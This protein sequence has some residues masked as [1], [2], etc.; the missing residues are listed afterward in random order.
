MNGLLLAYTK[1]LEKKHMS[2]NTMDAYVRDVDKFYN[3]IKDRKESIEGVEVISIMAYV[4]Y[5]QKAGKAI[6]SIVRN[7]VS[8]RNF[9]KYLTL[10]GIV[11]ENPILYYQIP[12][13]EHSVPEIL[14]VK[15]VDKL[16]SSPDLSTDK[17]I[18]DKAMLEVMYAA[19]MK[20]MELLNL[21]IYDID[22]KL[23][24]IRCSNSR[25]KER[26][27]PIGSVAVKYLKNYLRIRP[28]LNLYNL[29]TLF[30]N[31]KG[32]KMSR[33][34]FWK[35]VKYYAGESKIDKNINA[36]TLRHSFAVHLL[37]NGADIKSV[38]ELLGHKD[39]SATQVYSSVLKR[40]KIA[41]IYKKSHPRA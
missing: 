35:I 40:N 2:K 28:E 30:L 27:V 17:G 20:V 6:S 7:I 14:T 1:E 41:E 15:E 25:S 29:D 9:Y 8:L 4:Q 37:E 21:T 39:L 33:Q 22:L 31:L 34:G 13:V 24:Y 19:G 11:N 3:F 10:K 32:V 12:K 16:L 23:S 38:Q 5:L 36:F 18:R 26:I